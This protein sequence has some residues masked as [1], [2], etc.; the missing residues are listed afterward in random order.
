MPTT[1]PESFH[2]FCAL[3]DLLQAM[4]GVKFAVLHDLTHVVERSDLRYSFDP[5]ANDNNLHGPPWQCPKCGHTVTWSNWGICPWCKEK[6][7]EL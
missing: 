4:R 6:T 2:D 5:P 3:S 1:L 7:N